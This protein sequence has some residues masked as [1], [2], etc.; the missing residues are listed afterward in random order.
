MKKEKFGI[1]LPIVLLSYF[2]IILDNSIIFT[3]TNKIAQD[4]SLST[5]SLAWITNAYALTF[6]GF[7]LFAGKA[8][9]IIGRKNFF[10]IGLIIFSISSLFVGMATNA[11]VII[12]MRAVQ[13]F[14][15]AILAP[16][17]LALLMDSYQENMRTKAIAYYGATGGISASFGLVIGGIIATYTSWRVG[18]FINFPIGI[19]LLWLSI[20]Y[21]EKSKVYQQRIDYIGT[22]LSFIG[23]VALVY[24]LDGVVYRVIS[25]ILAIVFLGMF[26]RHESE[27]K[28]PIMPLTLFKDKERMYAYLTRFFFMGVGIS[29]FFLTPLAMQRVYDF[30]PLQSAIGFLPETIPQFITALIVT[31]LTTKYRISSIIIFGVSL[32]LVGVALSAYLGIQAGYWVGIGLPMVIIGIGQGAALGTLTI[33]GVAHTTSELS[34]AASGVVNTVHQIGGSVGLS[35]V[36]ALTSQYINPAKQYNISL[37]LLTLFAVIALVFSV[38]IFKG[39]QQFNKLHD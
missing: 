11:T 17:S 38:G 26:I 19:L 8:G 34:G 13:G 22:I 21:F 25:L 3:S 4:L 30:T 15:S 18:F 32:L 5:Q 28:N 23:I 37:V 35:I 2:M 39:E 16:S 36:V 7:L 27:T 29:Y 12:L 6:G 33:A 1:V 14:G 9:D 31:R 24:S 20:K 10:I